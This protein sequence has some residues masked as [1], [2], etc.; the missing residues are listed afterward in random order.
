M[1][2]YASVFMYALLIS[3]FGIRAPGMA[4]GDIIFWATVYM[5]LYS[6][7][8]WWRAHKPNEW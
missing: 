4:P 8:R 1:G 7:G 2:V 6:Y 3:E 5:K